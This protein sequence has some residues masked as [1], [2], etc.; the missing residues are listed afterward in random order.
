MLTSTSIHKLNVDKR[1]GKIRSIF[2]LLLN[3]INNNYLPNKARDLYI[4]NFNPEISDHDWRKIDIKSSTCRSLSDLFWLKIDWE[5]IKSELGEINILD[6]GAGKGT[7]GLKL[8]EF[9]KGISKYY[10]ID[11]YL[12]NEWLD[13]ER[14]YDFIKMKCHNSNSIS[15]VLTDD[16]NFFM[17]QSAVEHFDED[18]KYFYEIRNFINKSEKNTIQIHLIPS[19]ACL[20]TYLL[21]GVRQ[22]TPRT[23]SK[24]TRLFD[25]QK[26]Y[27]VLFKLGGKNCNNLHYKFSTIPLIFHTLHI[28]K[29]FDALVSRNEKF[30][31]L[32]KNAVEKDIK[33]K[34]EKCS[35][36]A[37]VIHSNYSKP[38]FKEMKTLTRE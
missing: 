12:Q 1:L 26:T 16:I 11:S 30:R 28:S 29:K 34:N 7:Y 15:E 13:L 38:I 19:A 37:L 33:Q 18:L 32:L 24:I 20:R 4:K 5:S 10:G 9:A 35:Y 6:T 27:S 21:H 2:W 3:F 23:I 36:Y 14:D 31:D 8:N 25:S 22:Y 17:S